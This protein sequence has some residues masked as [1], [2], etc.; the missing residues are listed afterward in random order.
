MDAFKV[1]G[2]N[3]KSPI[4]TWARSKW[5]EMVDFETQYRNVRD[6]NPTRP[7][8]LV[9]VLAGMPGM[10][11]TTLI[12]EA[13]K[14][15]S[16]ILGTDGYDTW[17]TG[18]D[19]QDHL[20]GKSIL[21]M[22]ELGLTD[23]EKDMKVLQRL[24]DTSTY[25]TDNDLL[26]N[27]GR[28]EAP[29]LIF[30]T[31]NRENIYVNQATPE[32]M[33]R[34]VDMHVH[35][36]NRGVEDH[37][38]KDPTR[39]PTDAELKKIFGNTA[40]KLSMLPTG[41]IDWKGNFINAVK[42]QGKANPTSITKNTL[43]SNI[44]V[45]LQS[46][47]TDFGHPGVVPAVFHSAVD[48]PII[49][50]K[51]PPG[52]GKSTFAS[53]VKGFEVINDPWTSTAEWNEMVVKV[54]H[55]ED[56]EKPLPLIITTNSNPWNECV[57][58]MQEEERSA[59]LRRLQVVEFSFNRKS[60]LSG[61][62]SAR[63][64]AEFGWSRCVSITRNGENIS[65]ETLR[66]EMKIMSPVKKVSSKTDIPIH[67]E[68]AN[69][70]ATTRLTVSQVVSDPSIFKLW[71]EFTII[72]PTYPVKKHLFE[73]MA[74]VPFKSCSHSG[75]KSFILSLNDSKI[76]ST[77]A[78]CAVAFADGVLN[79]QSTEGFLTV[80][81]VSS[82]V[83]D[84]MPLETESLTEH[85]K[86]WFDGWMGFL[87]SVMRTI[88]GMV[89]TVCAE[90]WRFHSPDLT[91][92][93]D[94]GGS[95]R[96][97]KRAARIERAHMERGVRET[98]EEQQQ[99][100]YNQMIGKNFTISGP[101]WADDNSVVDYSAQIRFDSGDCKLHLSIV[102]MSNNGIHH[103]WAFSHKDGIFTNKHVAFCSRQIGNKSVG[104]T[105]SY[106]IKNTDLVVIKVQSGNPYKQSGVPISKPQIG[107]KIFRLSFEGEFGPEVNVLAERN[108]LVEGSP[109]TVFIVESEV[110]TPGD[111]GLPWFRR[112][113][114]G[115]EM[116]GLHT[117]VLCGK[118]MVT[119]CADPSVTFH[120][121]GSLNR[122]CIYKTQYSKGSII[123]EK[124]QPSVKC[125][126][127]EGRFLDVDGVT[128]RALEPFFSPPK[129]QQAIDGF[130]Q[131]SVDATASYVRRII[132]GDSK[133]WSLTATIKSLDMST[134]AGPA[135]GCEKRRIFDDEGQVRP[136]F[137]KMFLAEING[138]PDPTV[139]VHLK[140]ELRPERKNKAFKTRPIFC[141]NVGQVVR[142]K[143]RLGDVL[144]KLLETAGDHPWTV[145]ISVN[146]GTWNDMCQN[147]SKCRYFLDADFS[148][149]DSC[150]SRKM[151]EQAI[152]A[153]TAP[154][155]Q[156]YRQECMRDLIELMKTRTQFGV[157]QCGLPSG[158]TGTSQLNCTI[159]VLLANESLYR[160]G[161]PCLGNPGCPLRIFC[162]GD[163]ILVGSMDEQSLE[164]LVKIWT[165]FGFAS[166]N[167]RKTGPPQQCDFKDLRF[168]KRELIN[169]NGF[170]MAG[171]DLDSVWRS[172][173]FGRLGTPY[174]F[175]GEFTEMLLS[176][177]RHIG[178]LQCFLS[179]IFQHGKKT[180]C[181]ESRRLIE[182][183]KGNGF[184]LPI[185]IPPYEQF[186]PTDILIDMMAEFD[187]PIGP[188]SWLNSNAMKVVL[189]VG[190]QNTGDALDSGTPTVQATTSGQ[191][192][193]GSV[194]G[195][196]GVV[197]TMAVPT[198]GI[199]T[200]GPT[201]GGANS[202]MD[203]GVRDSFVAVPGG[204]LSVTTTSPPGRQLI[205]LPITPAINIYTAWLA[206]MY[207]AWAGGFE[208][209]VVIG[210]N[211]FIGGKLI[212]CYIPPYND[213]NSF[214]I[215]EQ[216]AFPHCIL[217]VRMMDNVIL[218]CS[219][220]K[221]VL[222]HPTKSTGEDG[223]AGTFLLSVFTNIVSAS[224][225]ALTM[226]IKLLSRPSLTFDFQRLIP[227]VLS[228]G[229][230]S[231][232]WGLL[233][234]M[235]LSTP[236]TGSKTGALCTN[237]YVIPANSSTIFADDWMGVVATDGTSLLASGAI[238]P[239]VER[240]P[241][242]IGPKSSSTGGNYVGFYDE[243]GGVWDAEGSLGKTS[244]TF[245]PFYRDAWLWTSTHSIEDTAANQNV[246][247]ETTQPLTGSRDN[248]YL[249]SGKWG[250]QVGTGR[251]LFI[252][253]TSS[254]SVVEC[255]GF[256]TVKDFIGHIADGVQ[257]PTDRFTPPNGESIV[258]FGTFPPQLTS[259][260]NDY[261]RHLDPMSRD[262]A[263]HRKK[264]RATLASDE[265]YLFSMED[266]VGF[267]SVQCKLY[268]EGI[269]TTS[270]VPALSQYTGPINF[271]FVSV[272]PREYLLTPGRGYSIVPVEDPVIRAIKTWH[273]RQ[274]QREL[275]DQ[276]SDPLS[277]LL[278]ELG[279][280]SLQERH[281]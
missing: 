38:R 243:R 220:I 93:E 146:G 239:W 192:A 35:L 242:H 69:L 137:K 96:L 172:I 129:C 247:L 101:S 56:L 119:S 52:C 165:D 218:E 71:K 16:D 257:A 176:G 81:L 120:G 66:N 276:P 252:A 33:V 60:F 91:E 43:I 150:I 15:L 139:R 201:T 280:L 80:A 227:P 87:W 89:T 30:V 141:F 78:P 74:S 205:A 88:V 57:L 128:A 175:D 113:G 4:G 147:L 216:T 45:L 114:T 106:G 156:P 169:N 99:R 265:C 142:I 253:N 219:D 190:G 70:V 275:R 145:G 203:P 135:Y 7:Q 18:L 1:K 267:T 17:M 167:A 254:F 136:M 31:T 210:C 44:R 116:V 133:I 5:D 181:I 23:I 179:E 245:P 235:A 37:Y 193:D 211:N 195:L 39:K 59:L 173:E 27:K 3:D 213:P 234:A 266:S 178:A 32:A 46:R 20:T 217:D 271:K 36:H 144:C 154:I 191:Q 168:L 244:R 149:W 171:L 206:A 26:Q 215:E 125:G 160:S 109:C 221:K 51:G 223:I 77:A 187:R 11:K 123:Q 246:L 102:P 134:S 230:G 238:V 24:A 250:N 6:Q 76:K 157:T 148:Q 272:V 29:L 236:F 202:T 14:A 274:P 41:A 228:R 229:A 58:E 268:P 82:D 97:G 182:R 153:L 180:Y 224:G 212:A 204:S 28:R 85:I 121:G 124:L 53:E 255:D 226:D 10:G 262:A 75:I 104:S 90:K 241:V 107:E 163:D 155:P 131:M 185:C 25:V 231:D 251:P 256:I 68:M 222:W 237:L 111:C 110:S 42:T 263:T 279:R 174:T 159:H 200:A 240:Y 278:E 138:P 127:F 55:R 48:V 72:D 194:I 115:Y 225:G 189:H 207:N 130:S 63:D 132:G 103:G 19:H 65:R 259:F 233:E 198:A 67:S 170:Y 186:S 126:T 40:T 62:Y 83:V 269:L 208:V 98:Y 183:A 54:I 249:V 248:V 264:V 100:K 140:D 232:Q 162:Y 86:T 73:I 260:N 117:G 188:D 273:S 152:F 22:E 281:N 79:F 61:S 12:A 105:T 49:L 151:G 164:S 2:S 94:G 184:A 34:R 196:P 177:K 166:T 158:I 92:G 84:T 9:V 64:F 214:S 197:T 8:P 95:R 258:M 47:L 112:V 50:L 21:V 122:T 209:Q 270:G 118:V 199:Q 261:F 277:Q 161:R 143:S 13:S 108:I